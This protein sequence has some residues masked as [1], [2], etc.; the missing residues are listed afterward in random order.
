MKK[1]RTLYGILPCPKCGFRVSKR[2]HG[3]YFTVDCGNVDCGYIGEDYDTF[4]D[5]II[6]HNETC[7]TRNKE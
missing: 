5:A 7:L 6:E 3:E 2:T 1:G 4:N